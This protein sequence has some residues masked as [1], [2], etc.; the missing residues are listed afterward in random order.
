MDT[1]F[2]VVVPAA[3][4]IAA[5]Y[6]PWAR[7]TGR[8]LPRPAA[9]AIGLTTI[10][11]TVTFAWWYTG[12]PSSAIIVGWFWAASMAAGLSTGL[13]YILDAAVEANHRKDDEIERL[14]TQ[15]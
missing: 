14:R 15:L 9:Y 1:A 5:H 11:L 6:I 7:F 3:T 4:M 13:A 8:K 2:V 10:L 12:E